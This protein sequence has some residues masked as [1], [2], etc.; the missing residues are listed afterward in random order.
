MNEEKLLSLI[1]FSHSVRRSVDPV[2]WIDPVWDV[3]EAF[4]SEWYCSR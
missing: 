2:H 3:W 1:L 4:L